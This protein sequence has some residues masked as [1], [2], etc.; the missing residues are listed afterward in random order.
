MPSSTWTR[1]GFRPPISRPGAYSSWY[2][3][4]LVTVEPY[5]AL[6]KRLQTE[7][8]KIRFGPGWP[9]GETPAIPEASL[10]HGQ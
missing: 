1:S 9:P 5:S 7:A 8:C 3:V 6:Q 2:T 4:R 10:Q